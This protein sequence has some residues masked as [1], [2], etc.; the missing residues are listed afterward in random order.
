MSKYKF[1]EITSAERTGAGIY[2][3]RCNCGDK[4]YVG[5]TKHRNGF[6]GRFQDHRELLRAGIHDNI[7][8]QRSYNKH[9]EE[10]FYFE[11]LEICDKND[12]L[13]AKEKFWI[14]K[15]RSMYDQDGWNL[16]SIDDQL[17]RVNFSPKRNKNVLLVNDSGDSFFVK[18]QKEFCEKYDLDTGCVCRLFSGKLKSYRGW[19]VSGVK[20]DRI[21]KYV[22][23]KEDGMIE[24]VFSVKDFLKKSG[25]NHNQFRLL[26]TGKRKEIMG[27]SCKERFSKGIN[28][29]KKII[30]PCGRIVIFNKTKNLCNVSGLRESTIANIVNGNIK[31]SNGWKNIDNSILIQDLASGQIKCFT[32]QTDI[33]K[34]MKIHRKT[35]RKFLKSQTNSSR[36]KLESVD[37][38][39]VVRLEDFIITPNSVSDIE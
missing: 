12:N 33:L 34:F 36:F 9:G 38:L 24:M 6:F 2:C 37:S 17:K 22:F 26:I 30:S 27:W 13:F 11:I 8:L 3:I 35:L 10:S 29:D 39:P 23:I 28:V 16:Q 15:L 21:C 7:Y 5:Q 19:R 18:S 1:S 4:K 31:E 25:L 32:S 14:E 20:E